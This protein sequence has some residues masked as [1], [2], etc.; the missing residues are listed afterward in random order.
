MVLS[1]S[2]WGGKDIMGLF[3]DRALLQLGSPQGLAN[4]LAPPSDPSLTGLQ[5]L[6]NAAFTLPYATL[7]RLNGV[8]VLSI[9]AER[10]VLVL[11]HRQGS[12]MQA[13]PAYARTEVVSDEIDPLDPLWIDLAA[14]VQL[15]AILNVDAG[16][17]ESALLNDLPGQASLGDYR[18]QLPFF[19]LDGFMAQRGITTVEELRNSTS[20]LI[21][22][23]RY[24]AAKPFDP[25]DPGN[26]FKLPLSVPV[27]IREVTDLTAGLRDA[28]LAR[29][30]LERGLGYVRDPGAS[31]GP[32]EVKAPFVPTVVMPPPG[33]G[34]FNPAD[35]LSLFAG[36]G[37]LLL[38]LTLS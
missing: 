20:F 6:F 7:Y 28:K 11:R 36:E 33:G 9:R 14:E 18:A 29:L 37:V 15:S 30:A 35:A 2:Q 31:I 32:A 10:P 25:N 23:F 1:Q 24:Q 8:N 26:T 13:Q 5:I 16:L 34:T 4:A 38:F 22:Q 21:G 19:D 12:W 3:A 17:L 27:L